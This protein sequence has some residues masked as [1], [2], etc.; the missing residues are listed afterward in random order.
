MGL[1]LASRKKDGQT[2][3][4]HLVQYF[5]KQLKNNLTPVFRPVGV[6]LFINNLFFRT[7][8]VI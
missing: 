8:F 5:I 6:L 7:H 4:N 3:E 2:D 1:P